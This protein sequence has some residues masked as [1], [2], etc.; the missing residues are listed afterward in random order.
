MIKADIEKD[1]DKAIKA[2]DDAIA[3]YEELKTDLETQIK[4][5]E[6]AISDLEGTKAEKETEV[7]TT[8]EE[9]A[10]KK[11]ELKA[12]MQK[13]KDYEAGC[14]F[15]L[16]NFELRASNRQIEIDGLDKAKAILSGAEFSEVQVRSKAKKQLA[17]RRH[18]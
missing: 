15:I 13:I 12:I 6:T 11:D 2:E 14:D 10:T 7:E 1:L 17:V 18:Q 3:A 9:R 16:V 5:L 8:I 4:D